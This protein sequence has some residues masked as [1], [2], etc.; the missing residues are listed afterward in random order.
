MLLARKQKSPGR[1]RGSWAPQPFSGTTAIC[2]GVP[3]A[4]GVVSEEEGYVYAFWPICVGFGRQHQDPWPVSLGH[5]AS[6][7]GQLSLQ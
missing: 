5:S 6:E 3:L 2:T 7:E 4:R 1:W